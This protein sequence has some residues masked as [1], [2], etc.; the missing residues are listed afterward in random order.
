MHIAKFAIG[1]IVY[2]KRHGYRG[3]IADADPECSM[4]EDWYNT[5][6]DAV[7]ARDK[8]WYEVLIDGT[9][10]SIYVA[11]EAIEVESSPVEIDHPMLADYFSGF[12]RDHYQI[13][14]LQS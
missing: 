12:V 3:V 13:A 1:Q 2:H 11:E 8:P 7:D 10:I 4:D 5:K 14:H 6:T 9:P